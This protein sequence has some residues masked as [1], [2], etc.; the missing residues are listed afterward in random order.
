MPRS[1]PISLGALPNIAPGH[2]FMNRRE[3]QAAGL[4]RDWIKGISALNGFPAEA[5]VLSGGYE[6]DWDAGGT[7]LYT[8]EGGNL[9]GRQVADQ[10]L[11]GGNL[12]LH[13]SFEQQTPVRVI[14]QIRPAKARSSWYYA[15]AGLYKIERCSFERGRSGFMIW[16]F[17]LEQCL[18]DPLAKPAGF[19]V[20]EPVA[21]YQP[22]PR[23]TVSSSRLVRDTSLMQRVKQLYDFHCQV[24]LQRLA[25]PVRPYAEAAHLQPLGAPHHG[26]D[27]L[28]NLLCLCP[29]HHVLLDMGAWSLDDHFQLKGISGT[30]QIRPSHCLSVEWARYHRRT[31]YQPA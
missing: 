1:N 11:T 27:T 13:R 3:V 9:A 5:I 30:L 8:G 18:T 23:V 24:C 29:N 2:E 22:A 21:M 16:R 25:N 17:L 12:A 26:P 6:D 14:R 15:Y 4:H 28:D 19:E 7:I 10:T 20:Q 31:I